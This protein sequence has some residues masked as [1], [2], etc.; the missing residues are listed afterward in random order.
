MARFRWEKGEE[1]KEKPKRGKV[2]RALKGLF[3]MT[4]WSGALAAVLYAVPVENRIPDFVPSAGTRR[5]LKDFRQAV[6]GYALRHKAA[7]E[8]ARLRKAA[9]EDAARRSSALLPPEFLAR[10]RQE[11]ERNR[12][13]YESGRAGAPHEHKDWQ[14]VCVGTARLDKL[15]EQSLTEGQRKIYNTLIG[16]MTTPTGRYLV[17]FAKEKDVYIC[18]KG[19]TG[20]DGHYINNYY[21]VTLDGISYN[22][23]A[24]ELRHYWQ[25]RHN[26]FQDDNNSTELTYNQALILNL[27][28]ETDAAVTG[29][30]VDK[31]AEIAVSI[32][33]PGYR[34]TYEEIRAKMGDKKLLAFMRDQFTSVYQDKE[35]WLSSY[36]K[37]FEEDEVKDKASSAKRP[38]TATA[39]SKA[40]LVD[41]DFRILGNAPGYGNYM[42]PDIV[43]TAF[44]KGWS[45]SH[46]KGNVPPGP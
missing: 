39:E 44:E 23:I 10:A 15:S 17:E 25:G 24:H 5:I 40:H 43:K 20:A 16:L 14:E 13:G 7:D 3:N 37:R 34:A 8:A 46:R 31:E 26:I 21:T 35:S 9:E 11:A 33:G 38:K 36:A 1:K 27:A 32:G 41:V 12:R 42:T 4:V 2:S 29:A 22:T 6:A 30:L 45:L 28:Y 19:L 18:S